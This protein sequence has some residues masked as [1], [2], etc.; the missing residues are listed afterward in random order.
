MYYAALERQRKQ[1]A[2]DDAHKAR[3]AEFVKDKIAPSP[4]RVM[5]V[6]S[7]GYHDEVYASLIYAFAQ[8]PST[9]V[10]P[11]LWRPRFNISDILYSFNLN[12][13]AVPRNASVLIKEG[14]KFGDQDPLPDV[15]VSTTCEVDITKMEA[16]YKK[17]LDAGTHMFC[18]IHHSDRWHV[19]TRY[20]VY[21]RI[22]PWL[23][24]GQ[25]TFLFLSEHTMRYAQS[26]VVSSWE[27]KHQ[28]AVKDRMKVFVP[29][30]PVSLRTKDELSIAVQGNYESSRRDYPGLFGQ[31]ENLT[32][33]D[34][35]AETM[36]YGS[37]LKDL[38]LHLIGSG[39]TRPEVPAALKDQVEF[40]E[41][42]NF[43]QFYD[44]LADSSALVPA[45]AT[46]EYYDRKAS[47]SVPASL[48]AGTPIVCTR[49]MLQA[50]TYLTEDSVWLQ[51]FGEEDL[52]TVARVVSKGDAFIKRGK[53][54]VKQRLTELL[55]DNEANIMTWLKDLK[56]KVERTGK[57]VERPTEA[58]RWEWKTSDL[59]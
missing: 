19:D 31:F 27:K 23:E 5:L 9:Y 2:A 55:G 15:L 33:S 43:R 20:K 1:Q 22:Q 59:N 34:G 58:W 44:V 28:D 37:K 39:K 52:D 3:L 49:Q 40:N 10:T 8:L 45:F 35:A 36:G 51:E 17:L 38:R 30:F 25:V 50:Y 57:E 18:V 56:F 26:K 32:K 16:P 4:L 41:G 11:Y 42:L 12:N 46:D 24:K 29:V 14:E 13:L 47:S 21:Q 54:A 48:I 6:E 53:M 7:G